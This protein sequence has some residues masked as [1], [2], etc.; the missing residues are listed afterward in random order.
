MDHA[1]PDLGS[2]KRVGN[3]FCQAPTEIRI[4][5]LLAGQELVERITTAPRNPMYAALQFR[6]IREVVG[7]EIV[8]D[9]Q[10]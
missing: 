3:V 8:N 4:D 10:G 9:G 6:N 1:V 7:P 5:L 2:R